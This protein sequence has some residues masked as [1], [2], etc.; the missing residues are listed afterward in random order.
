VC[1]LTPTEEELNS[2]DTEGNTC[3][4]Y[5]AVALNLDLVKY[6]V[7]L[8]VR[9]CTTLTRSLPFF[10]RGSAPSPFILLPLWIFHESIS[11]NLIFTTAP[12]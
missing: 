3:L 11:W 1:E 4:F 5:A 10:L 7:E 9:Y 12:F 2:V 8:M 6:L